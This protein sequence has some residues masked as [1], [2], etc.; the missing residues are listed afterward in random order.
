VLGT[1]PVIVCDVCD[2]TASLA[3]PSPLQFTKYCSA[4]STFSHCT[5]NDSLVVLMNL[6]LV[7]VPGGPVAYEYTAFIIQVVIPS[8]QV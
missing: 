7:G 4:S 1:N 8:K 3:L 5:I 6:M 2:V